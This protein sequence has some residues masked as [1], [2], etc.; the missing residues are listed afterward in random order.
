MERPRFDPLCLS[1]QH[2]GKRIKS[3]KIRYSWEFLLLNKKFTIDLF[4]SRVSGKRRILVNGTLHAE[5]KRKRFSVSEFYLK[6]GSVSISIQEKRENIFD[7]IIDGVSFETEILVKR[8]TASISDNT[9][10]RVEL[11]SLLQK[12]NGKVF[13]ETPE[14]NP[15]III[16]QSRNRSPLSNSSTP[17]NPG[18][19]HSQY[20]NM[21]WGNGK[22]K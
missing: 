16:D 4:V 2:V 9:T 12:N 8:Q 17:S 15:E 5:E 6:I 11:N 7:L 22:F 3:T 1:V 13:K 18:V 20:D 19:F 10:Q 21:S 14:A